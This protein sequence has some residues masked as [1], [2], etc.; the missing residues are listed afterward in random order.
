MRSALDSGYE[1][2]L[3]FCC[4]QDGWRERHTPASVRFLGRKVYLRV[5]VVLLTAR[6]HGLTEA[7]RSRLKELA[8]EDWRHP[9]TGL[10][11]RFGFGKLERWYYLA[12][13][14]QDPVAAARRRRR[15]DAGQQC[16]LTPRLI[17]VVRARYREHPGWTVQL[18]YRERQGICS[19]SSSSPITAGAASRP[20]VSVG[21]L[22]WR[23]PSCARWR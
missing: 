20:C 16:G 9:V 6:H 13:D 15:C 19:L 7:R 17:E 12:R 8:T 2:R 11:L 21:W 23:R 1:S 22:I 4:A 14:P 5:I 18:H 3:N 10:P